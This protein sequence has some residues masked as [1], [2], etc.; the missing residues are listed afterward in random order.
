M[1]VAN[2]P[3]SC[4]AVARP[5]GVMQVNSN[6]ASGYFTRNA[7][8]SGSAARISPTETACSQIAP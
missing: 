4:C 2:A 8:T 7:A 3:Y 5:V 1:I 6:W